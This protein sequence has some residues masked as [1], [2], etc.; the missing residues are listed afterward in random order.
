MTIKR[1]DLAQT[2]QM[3]ANLTVTQKTWRPRLLAALLA[4]AL[5]MLLAHASLAAAVTF[6]K[7]T[8]NGLFYQ[9]GETNVVVDHPSSGFLTVRVSDSGA[10]S[11]AIYISP[12]ASLAGLKHP[13]SGQFDAEGK[14]T[15]T[16]MSKA[17]FGD[18]ITLELQYP[19][20]DQTNA[21]TGQV[22]CSNWTA[23]VLAF[24]A[25]SSQSP[26]AG[27]Y[28]FSLAK[29]AADPGP[30]GIGVG[31]ISVSLAGKLAC[32]GKLPDG[33]AFTQSLALCQE[34]RWP[35]YASL[36]GGSGSL[37]GWVEFAGGTGLSGAV[38]WTKPALAKAKYF[39]QGLTNVVEVMGLPFTPTRAGHRALNFK[40]GLVV[41]SGGGL[42]TPFTNAVTLST[43]GHVADTTKFRLGFQLDR[44]TGQFT[45][46]AA[47]PGLKG[48]VPLRGAV[49]QAPLNQGYG[50]FLH[51]GQSGAVQFYGDYQ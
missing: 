34:G 31:K 37:V 48:S 26:Q 20:P 38:S 17:G 27:N 23:Q 41:F 49:F 3:K 51:D 33:T 32:A 11:G 10:F 40:K 24:P 4:G 15:L 39:S 6:T 8:Y 16:L 42:S 19:A 30:D 9:V 12:T 21:I 14:K 35:L 36:Y 28:T 45:G 1:V 46:S 44:F 7:S 47:L 13:L 18:L 29:P 22:S 2:K 43:G 25:Y 50:Y 5:T